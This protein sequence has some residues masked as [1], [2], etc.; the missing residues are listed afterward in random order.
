MLK[1]LG[2]RIKYFRNKLGIT[3]VQLSNMTS[4]EQPVISRY[5]NDI[6]TP[7]ISKLAIIANAL[8]VSVTELLGDE[9]V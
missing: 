8:N 4:I 5:E 9:P 7:P 1:V 6:I 3:Q 2:E